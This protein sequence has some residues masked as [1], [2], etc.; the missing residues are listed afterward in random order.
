MI[1]HLVFSFNFSFWFVFINN[2]IFF[3][4]VGSAIAYLMRFSLDVVALLIKPF[5]F[6]KYILSS[7]SSSITQLLPIIL[8]VVD[9]VNRLPSESFIKD[10]WLWWSFILPLALTIITA[11]G[12]LVKR[13][14]RRL[15]KHPKF[16]WSL[17]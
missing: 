10:K 17:L 13:L 3:Y 1:S 9:Y 11:M 14:P 12:L 2:V 7:L 15:G 5:P 6:I 4:L 16:T 8:Q